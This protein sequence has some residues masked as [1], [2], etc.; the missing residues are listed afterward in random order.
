[1]AASAPAATGT[2]ASSDP[3]D[4]NEALQRIYKAKSDSH[5]RLHDV[6]HAIANEYPVILCWTVYPPL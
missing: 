1:M 4:L 6:F 3:S 2:N 5:V